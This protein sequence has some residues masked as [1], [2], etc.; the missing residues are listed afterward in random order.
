MPTFLTG[1]FTDQYPSRAEAAAGEQLLHQHV[2]LCCRPDI[3][4]A[5][6]GARTNAFQTHNEGTGAHF[7]LPQAPRGRCPPIPR[8]HSEVQTPV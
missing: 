1:A 5:Q 3:V 4:P 6:P 7:P 8:R 2:V